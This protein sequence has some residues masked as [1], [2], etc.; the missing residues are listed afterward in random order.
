MIIDVLGLGESITTYKRENN[1][2]NITIGVNDIAKHYFTDYLVIVDQP[3]RFPKERLANIKANKQAKV[4]SHIK[5]WAEHFN[6]FNYIKLEHRRSFL[7]LDSDR[8]SYSN[9][10]TYLACILAY[11]L[12]AK[13][14]NLYGADFVTHNS[15]S[16][17]LA[18]KRT[19]SDFIALS[20]ELSKK[21]IIFKVA[22]KFSALYPHIKSLQD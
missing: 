10:S 6:N 5:I 1:K 9:N 11:K 3:G 13:E 8:Y 15:L 22:S 2:N 14:I 19:L 12:G 17:D 4:Y 7:D 21:G 16:S 20:A 18:F